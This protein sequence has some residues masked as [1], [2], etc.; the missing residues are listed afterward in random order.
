MQQPKLSPFF[1]PIRN[2]IK[3]YSNIISI[4]EKVEFDRNLELL[5]QTFNQIFREE[6]RFARTG[7]LTRTPKDLSGLSRLRY[8]DRTSLQ[9]PHLQGEPEGDRHQSE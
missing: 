5:G 8:Q 4:L 9:H 2:E 1:G 3:H 7:F 6:L